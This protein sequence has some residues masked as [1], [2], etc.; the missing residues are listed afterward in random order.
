M[1]KFLLFF[2]IFAVLCVRGAGAGLVGLYY[3]AASD[4]P[5]FKNLT[6]YKP[7]VVST[8]YSRDGKVM[9]NL[10]AEKR[11]LASLSEM[12]DFLP[13]AFLAAEDSSFYQHEGVDPLAIFRAF[14]KNLQ[15]GGIRQGGSTITQQIVKR[16]LL[17]PEKSLKRK[18]KE[19][20]LAYRLERY[21]TKDEILTIYLNQIYLGSR[22]YGVEAAAR[23]YFGV[24]VGQLT[25]AQ[26]AIL[27][28]LPQAPSRYS[29]LKDLDAAKGRQKYVLG[30]MLEMG[31]INQQQHDA[32]V[33]EVLVFKSMDE[34]T[35]GVGAYYM[36]EVRR[37]L[38]EKFGEDL[39]YTGGLRVD[40]AC[41]MVHQEAAEK[42]LRKALVDSS[43]R[44]GWKGT[45]DTLTPDKW[46]QFLAQDVPADALKNGQWVKALVTEASGKGL[47]VKYGKNT[48]LIDAK[49]LGWTRGKGP[50]P[51]EV[52]FVSLAQPDP[53]AKT[54]SPKAPRAG[55]DLILQQE[56]DVQGAMVSL[57]P[58][59]GQ[60]LACV[61]GFSFE[62]S[63]FNRATQAL[64]QCGSAFKPIVYSAAIDEGM[65]P[66][67]V[68]MDSPFIY[69]DPVTHKVWKPENYEGGFQ[70]AMSLRSA[71][72]KSRNLVTIRV[73]QQI[74]IQKVIKRAKEMGIESEL[75]PYLPISLGAGAV[76]LI[77]LCQA[78]T[79][80]AHGG[81][82]V[83]PRFVLSVKG[84]DGQELYRSEP[85]YHEAMSPQTA[86]VMTAMLR[87]VVRAGTAGKAM[88]IGKPIAGKT[89]TTNDEQDAWFVGF[90]PYLLT[91]VY[92]GFDQV[93]PMGKGETGGTAALPAFVDYRMAVEPYYPTEDFVAPPGIVWASVDGVSM[94]FKEG[95]DRNAFAGIIGGEGNVNF[96]DPNAPLATGEQLL[97]Q[98]Y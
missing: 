96:S 35:W 14:L 31:W 93:Q 41:D 30:R 26:A 65:T 47:V 20:I 73:A 7:P 23:T 8:V 42:A 5:G 53:K 82:Q 84:P 87:E 90:T 61:G 15:A 92:L 10:Y 48:G 74:G 76:H 22:A 58:R 62:K 60:V 56:P 39:V 1:R 59:D 4:L 37:W 12:P 71:L 50:K 28:G 38:V 54:P 88:A 34:Q 2:A 40:T 32:A 52:V 44:R 70:G 94:P 81:Q 95:Q 27:A 24:H 3:W 77:N 85:E 69:E 51:G 72:A 64:R 17:T 79:S 21:L 25:I 67:T 86:F 9:G 29:P 66:A 46:A 89:G 19:A 33:R 45:L 98:M 63:Q 55:E 43:K 18:L 83:K 91:G 13:K 97:K 16:L 80:F 75:Q 57:D 11:F 68:V 36:E 49:Y 78:Y 6:E